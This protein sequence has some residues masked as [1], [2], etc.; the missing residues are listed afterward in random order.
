MSNEPTK[1]VSNPGDPFDPAL[2]ALYKAH[3]GVD[4]ADSTMPS[5]AADARIR[6]LAH[7]A[8]G[9]DAVRRASAVIGAPPKP[10]AALNVAP[11]RSNAGSAASPSMRARPGWQSWIAASWF[12]PSLAF[13]T[14]ASLSVVIV[15][16][17]PREDIDIERPESATTAAPPAVATAP[18]AATAPAATTAPASPPATGM[19]KDSVSSVAPVQSPKATAEAQA[20]K[21]TPEAQAPKAIAEAQSPA[22]KD[23]APSTTVAPTVPPAAP[24][25]AAL[26]A[27]AS[28]REK[29]SQARTAAESVRRAPSAAEADSPSAAAKTK[30]APPARAASRLEEQSSGAASAATAS[31]PASPQSPALKQAQSSSQAPARMP[32]SAPPPPPSPAATPAAPAPNPFPAQATADRRA[33]KAELSS[34]L[35]AG[36]AAAETAPGAQRERQEKP[37]LQREPADF[38]A[39]NQPLP[40]VRDSVPAYPSEK[41]QSA[42]GAASTAPKLQAAPRPEQGQSE[43]AA[44]AA[45]ARA[46]SAARRDESLQKRSYEGTTTQ[47]SPPRDP[48][49][50]IK[51]ILK[52]R[53]EG[54][55]EQVL[56][57]LVEFR[58]HYPAY[59]LPD[60]LKALAAAR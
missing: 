54:K 46:Q 57:E 8:G 51:S 10:S 42:A 41:R 4:S 56:K 48:A 50:W 39:G 26:R 9:V 18:G 20:R 29:E 24:A 17:M 37:S 22:A 13:A 36:G 5:A 31:A 47:T 34:N 1:P 32:Q 7:E 3:L 23:N 35:A 27:S 60:E 12:K 52:L 2:A 38:R 59:P 40:E 55:S 45:L 44:I 28:S 21:A 49:D 19:A 30:P 25:S 6:A 33:D 11:G 58:K 53:A 16:L 15:A 14:L 43:A